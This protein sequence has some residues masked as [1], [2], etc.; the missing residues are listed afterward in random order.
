MAGARER[1]ARRTFVVAATLVVLAAVAVA[2]ILL[3]K[4]PDQDETLAA[5]A[6][7]TAMFDTDPPAGT[8][9]SCDFVPSISLVVFDAHYDC[10]A[11]TCG[12]EF[13][14]LQIT[15][16]LFGGWS[17]RVTSGGAVGL[18]SEGRTVTTDADPSHFDRGNCP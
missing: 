1:R 9:A 3:A 2:I 14:R 16:Q 13:A 8:S 4:R 7:E 18:P 17:Y 15:H 12:N 5:S 11:R 10:V 6:A